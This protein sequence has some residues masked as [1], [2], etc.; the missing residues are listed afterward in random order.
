MGF[1]TCPSILPDLP[2]MG[3]SVKYGQIQK[4]AFQR[5]GHAFTDITSKAEWTSLIAS[6]SEDKIVITP[7]VEAPTPEGGS[8]VTFGSGNQ[9][10]DGIEYVMGSNPVKMTFQLRHYPQS[11]I[12]ALR[13]LTRFPDMGVYLLTSTG[14]VALKGDDGFS[15]IPVRSLFVG[16]LLLHGLAQP[17]RNI[18]SF[19][20]RPATSDYMELAVPS[21][22]P[23]EEL[24]NADHS[25]G[26]G[27]FSIAFNYSFDV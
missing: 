25:L 18:M 27:S 5:T 16:D 1:Y 21:F 6:T 14:I 4:I 19:R 23:I 24:L 11:I 17:D 8:E 10:R 9:V 15:A 22:N 12:R 7:F 26:D 3:C 20:M 2:N 13:H